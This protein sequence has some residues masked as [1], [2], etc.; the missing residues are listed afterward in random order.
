MAY[1][2]GRAAV[3][4]STGALEAASGN[5]SD[6]VHVDGSSGPCG[7]S[8]AGSAGPNF[9]DGEVPAGPVNG[10]KTN[11]AGELEKTV[12]LPLVA[13]V[14]FSLRSETAS[15]YVPADVLV[16]V[17]VALPIAVP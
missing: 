6:C 11:F 17:T 3:I 8:G 12:R 15:V 5:V 16:K 13:P 2:V 4:D 1:T 7:A 14:R 10:A 9:T